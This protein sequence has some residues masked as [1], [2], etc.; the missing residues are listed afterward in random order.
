MAFSI[1]WFNKLNLENNLSKIIPN[2]P[3]IIVVTIIDA[4]K[5]EYLAIGPKVSIAWDSNSP[6]VSEN[7]VCDASSGRNNPP[8][9]TLRMIDIDIDTRPTTIPAEKENNSE[10]CPFDTYFIIE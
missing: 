10:S 9:N 1:Y 7:N 2:I 3:K 5:V 6:G 4:I 8:T